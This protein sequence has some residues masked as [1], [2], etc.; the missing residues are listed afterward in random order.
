MNPRFPEYEA[1]VLP[2]K[3]QELSAFTVSYGLK[4]NDRYSSQVT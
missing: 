3:P 2:T 4:M 1:L